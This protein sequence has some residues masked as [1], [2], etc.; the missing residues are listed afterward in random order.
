MQ[1]LQVVTKT[2]HLHVS[3]ILSIFSLYAVCIYYNVFLHCMYTQIVSFPSQHIITN[4]P[5]I[6]TNSLQTFDQVFRVES[7]GKNK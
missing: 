3:V 6:N 2:L 5:S 1:A 4:Y 7:S